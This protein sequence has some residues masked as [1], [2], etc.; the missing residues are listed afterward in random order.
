M[1]NDTLYAI[2]LSLKQKPAGDL[3]GR[4]MKFFADI[5]SVY[6]ANR[7][8]LSAV[9]TLSDAEVELLSDKDLTDAERI[10]NSCFDSDISIITYDNGEYPKTLKCADNPPPVLYCRGRFPDF[11]GKLV[12][13]VVGPREMS[14]YGA[15]V[16][17]RITSSLAAAGAIIL[18][19]LALGI[20]AVASASAVAV[21]GT[22][23]A[24]VACG[25]DVVY[26]KTHQKLSDEIIKSGGAIISEYPPKTP[27][28]RLNFR[29][30]NRF[31]PLIADATLVIEGTVSGGTAITA[32]CALDSGKP[33]YT[34]PADIT[35]P[36]HELPL[37]LMR[38]GAVPIDSAYDILSDFEEKYYSE[39]NIAKAE[40][41]R[42]ITVGELI[43][44]YKIGMKMDSEVYYDTFIVDKKNK[45]KN[46][47][48]NVFVR[49]SKKS[50][51]NSRE[52]AAAPAKVA[53]KYTAERVSASQDEPNTP[54]F[55]VDTL[56]TP[57]EETIRQIKKISPSALDI[58]IKLSDKPMSPEEMAD[59]KTPFSEVLSALTLLEISGYVQTLPGGQ[60]KRKA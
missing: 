48:E 20:D 57:S 50:D 14:P 33:I 45:N 53:D 3:C 19:G 60:I 49:K 7:A 2:W 37:E 22:T 59:E 4:L 38:K 24:I 32:K 46:W 34:V 16:C 12:I 41:A 17:A 25:A 21:G 36:N 31:F 9:N 23:C 8:V 56:S 10:M 6:V 11:T 55:S 30:R 35:E 29:D 1:E 44:E 43:R 47:F 42:K 52:K 58:Y 28:D 5:H 39:I 18:S 40:S 13:S 26:P 51:E 27:I 15:T 54:D